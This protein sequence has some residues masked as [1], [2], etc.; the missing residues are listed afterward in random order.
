ML[1]DTRLIYKPTAFLYLSK[2]QLDMKKKGNIIYINT[3]KER[4]LGI[5][6]MIYVSVLYENSDKNEQNQ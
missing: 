4:H 6:L 1:H 2:E 5:N 3:K